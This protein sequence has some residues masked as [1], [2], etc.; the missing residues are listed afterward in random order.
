MS[1]IALAV[2]ASSLSLPRSLDRRAMDRTW[3]PV[4]VARLHYHLAWSTRGQAPVLVGRRA[5]TLRTLL[6][7]MCRERSLTLQAVAITPAQVRLVVSLRP[8][9]LAAS[10]VR[11]LKGR[12][13]LALLRQCPDLRVAL[14]GHLAWNDRYA[15]ATV[16]PRQLPRLIERLAAI[17]VASDL[18]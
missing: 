9:Q 14:G 8:S 16:S 18:K 17:G 4:C 12:S 2:P 1:T 5:A 13:A 7:E 15:L 11:E 6:E 3:Q 10:V